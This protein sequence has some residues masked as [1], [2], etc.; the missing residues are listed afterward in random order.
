MPS[1]KLVPGLKDGCVR[2][3]QGLKVHFTKEAEKQLED[4]ERNDPRYRGHARE[5]HVQAVEDYAKVHKPDA[6][7]AN[8]R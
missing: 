8:I 7:R 1:P 5:M 4:L 3:T 2:S 6:K